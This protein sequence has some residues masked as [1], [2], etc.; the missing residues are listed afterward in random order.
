MPRGVKM[1]RFGC[2]RLIREYERRLPKRNGEE[3][4]RASCRDVCRLKMDVV[5]KQFKWDVMGYEVS[6]FLSRRI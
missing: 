6:L 2:G 4:E 3:R 1:A 5:G